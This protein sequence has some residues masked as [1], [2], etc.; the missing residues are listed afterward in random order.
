MT[1][2]KRELTMLLLMLVAILG[3]ITFL[4]ARNVL[5]SIKTNLER[6]ESAEL[7]RENWN[8]ISETEPEMQ[9]DFARLQGELVPYA[10]AEDVSSKLYNKLQDMIEEAGLRQIRITPGKERAMSDKLNVYNNTFKIEVSGESIPLRRFLFLAS[11][12]QGTA[13]DVVAFRSDVKRNRVGRSYVENLTANIT[14]ECAYRRDDR[15]AQEFRSRGPRPPTPASA[16]ARP[17]TPT[18]N[19]PGTP[20]ASRLAIPGVPRTPIKRP[21][22]RPSVSPSASSFTPPGTAG[23]PPGIFKPP[24]PAAAATPARTPTIPAPTARSLT[25]PIPG[26]PTNPAPAARPIPGVPAIPST[27][28]TTRPGPGGAPPSLNIPSRPGPSS[29]RRP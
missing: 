15:A 24:V 26:L 21:N 12:A 22:A 8:A 2:Q 29:T 28:V 6:V 3:L 7:D 14:V 13:M 25:R 5:P 4:F 20:G 19:A 9:R 23:L 27:P 1:L 10:M 18:P 16:T 11:K 17:P